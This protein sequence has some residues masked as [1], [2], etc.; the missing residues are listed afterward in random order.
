MSRIFSYTPV[1]LLCLAC[2][3]FVAGCNGDGRP[4]RVKVS[5]KVTVD[6]IPVT[7]GGVSFK[8]VE[9]GRPGG[10]AIQQDGS[11]NVTMYRKNDG[12]PLGSYKVA[13][14]GVEV[15]NDSSQRW[16]A[17]KKYASHDTSGYVIEITEETADMNFDLSWEG[18][19][20]SAPWVER[21]NHR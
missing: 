3:V 6:G 11:Y 9:G 20:H 18:D 14:T 5:G 7:A 2:F 8:P 4:T 12:L 16:L 1:V 19:D 21:N 10:G 13:V 17:P 15:I